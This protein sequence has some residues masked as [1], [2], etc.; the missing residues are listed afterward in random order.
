[1]NEVVKIVR[2]NRA[3]WI[4]LLASTLAIALSYFAEIVLNAPPCRLCLYQR[5]GYCLILLLSTASVFPSRI[6]VF[7]LSMAFL[8]VSLIGIYHFLIQMGYISDPCPIPKI[9][10]STEF[11]KMLEKPLGCSKAGFTVLSAPA[12]I[13]SSIYSGLI[14][15]YLLYLNKN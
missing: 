8:S 15:V 5:W 13:L 2:L 9:S 11:L 12:S 4:S 14:S 1:M 6:P 10:N 7:S 3:I